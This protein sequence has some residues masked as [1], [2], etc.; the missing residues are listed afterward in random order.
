LLPSQTGY[1]NI[2]L[3]YFFLGRFQEAIEMYQRSIELAPD[4]YEIWGDL[5]DACRFAEGQTELATSA[6]KRAIE[7]AESA[8]SVNPSD[9]DATVLLAHYYANIDES[10]RA[11]QLV[12]RALKLAPQNMYVR[13]DAAVTNVSLG[14]ADKA[15]A[16]IEQAVELG[17]PV[18]LLS[19]DAGLAPLMET[20]RFRALL[21]RRKD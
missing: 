20:D 12:A 1:A 18:E 21:T 4:D 6:Y 11:R 13:Y 3:S 17:Y 7:L 10:E 9:A 19:L 8:L 14:E 5:G 2:G 15:L 16:A